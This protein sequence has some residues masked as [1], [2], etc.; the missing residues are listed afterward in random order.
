MDRQGPE[1]GRP[2]ANQGLGRAGSIEDCVRTHKEIFPD[3]R[4]QKRAFLATRAQKGILPS[5]HQ[6]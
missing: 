3:T 1:G 2:Q 5:H 6:S 4:A